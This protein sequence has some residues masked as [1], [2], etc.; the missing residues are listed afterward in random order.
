MAAVRTNMYSKGMP[1]NQLAARDP[2]DQ[3]PDG[4]VRPLVQLRDEGSS[5]VA[6]T[7]ATG[8]LPATDDNCA[9]GRVLGTH[10]F[11][12]RGLL[13]HGQGLGGM[14][15]SASAVSAKSKCSAQTLRGKRFFYPGSFNRQCAAATF[16]FGNRCG[17]SDSAQA[18][19][20]IRTGGAYHGRSGNSACA[21]RSMA[22]GYQRERGAVTSPVARQLQ[23]LNSVPRRD[24]SGRH[25][26]RPSGVLQ[27]R[28]KR[29]RCQ[30]KEEHYEV[31]Q[32]SFRLPA[33]RR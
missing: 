17:A 20:Q 2:V 18:P 5:L 22:K 3:V 1:V 27:P 7:P 29:G 33:D 26:G 14:S 25:G 6:D 28:S 11:H 23:A 30:P 21:C 4:D 10:A 8:L 16:V 31:G 9:P 15:F 13:A 32:M 12:H 19:G 24:F